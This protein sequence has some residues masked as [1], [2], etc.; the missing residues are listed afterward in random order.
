MPVRTLEAHVSAVTAVA[1]APDGKHMLSG[2]SDR[3]LR[4]WRASDG[5]LLRTFGGHTGSIESV[6]FAADGRTFAS[7]SSD[8]T[9]RVWRV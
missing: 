5:A 9:A 1:F 6:A 8:G 4:L 7:G 3:T 2:S